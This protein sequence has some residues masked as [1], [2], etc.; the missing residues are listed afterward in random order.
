MSRP[1]EELLE[2]DR[3]KDIVSGSTTCVPGR[4]AIEALVPQQDVASLEAEF[5]LVREAIAYLRAGSELGF[6]S[7]ADPDAWLARLGMPGSVLL[8][9]ELLD[10]ASLGENADAV[11]QTFKSEAAK[12]PRLAERA[13]ALADFRPLLTAIRRAVLP[14]GE[15]SDDASP[16][17]KRIRASMI[18]A[19]D[20]DSAFARKHTARARGTGGRGLRHAAERPLR[21]SGARFRPSRCSGSG[22]RGER[23]GTDRV[24]RAA[25]GH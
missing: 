1:A 13:A 24:R 5:E 12:Y 20:T 25:R 3:L 4:R 7:L 19:R 9:A 8:P 23:H 14:N 11:R 21:D 22:P 15:I 10:V 2:F 18:Q 16:Q 17:L 6:G